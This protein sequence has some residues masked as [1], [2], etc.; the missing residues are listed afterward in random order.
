MIDHFPAESLEALFELG[1][2]CGAKKTNAERRIVP[3]SLPSTGLST[4]QNHSVMDM[5]ERRHQRR[6]RLTII[7]LQLN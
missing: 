1:S 5:L 6:R 7:G 4:A 3:S 2:S